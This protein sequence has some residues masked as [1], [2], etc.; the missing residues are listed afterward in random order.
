MTHV[1]LKNVGM[2]FSS[3]FNL[4]ASNITINETFT[5]LKSCEARKCTETLFSFLGA[6]GK[7]L[8]KTN[9]VVWIPGD[10]ICTEKSESSG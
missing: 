5:S 6:D 7:R 2:A 8:S 10:G 3:D 1:S 4:F 9:I